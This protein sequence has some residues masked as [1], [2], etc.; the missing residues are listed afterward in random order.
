MLIND[1]G[2]DEFYKIITSEPESFVTSDEDD[3]KFIQMALENAF[4]CSPLKQNSRVE[5]IEMSS[6]HLLIKI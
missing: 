2:S 4:T 1:E 3:V 6:Y 5:L